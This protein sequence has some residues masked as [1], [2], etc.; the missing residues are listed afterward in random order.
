MV[1]PRNTQSRHKFPHLRLNIEAFD[2]VKDPRINFK[3]MFVHYYRTQFRL[4]TIL[5]T[6]YEHKILLPKHT[7]QSRVTPVLHHGALLSHIETSL[8]YPAA[9]LIVAFTHLEKLVTDLRR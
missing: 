8:V 9:A 7:A 6:G 3:Q 2:A 1:S 4:L 5:A